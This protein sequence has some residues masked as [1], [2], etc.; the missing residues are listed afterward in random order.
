MPNDVP[1]FTALSSVQIQS[2]NGQIIGDVAQGPFLADS[3]VQVITPAAGS[4]VDGSIACV[5]LHPAAGQTINIFVSPPAPVVGTAASV[6][7]A[8]AQATTAGNLLT[9]AVVGDGTEPTT[10]AVGW[11]KAQSVGTPWAALWVKPNCGNNEAAPTFTASN[12]KAPMIAQL[13]EWSGAATAN[14]VNQ[15]GSGAAAPAINQMTAVNA[16]ADG[17]SGDLFL[18]C[19][20]WLVSASGTPSYKSSINN[21]TVGLQ[22]GTATS[23]GGGNNIAAN[24][25]F[26]IIPA[27]KA[28]LPL[29]TVG[30]DWDVSGSSVPAQGTIPS[31]VFA[32]TPGQKYRLN[33]IVASIRPDTAAQASSLIQVKDGTSV[34]WSIYLAAIATIDA[35]DRADLADLRLPGTTGNSMTVALGS[36]GAAVTG[37]VAAGVYL[38]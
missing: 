16:A 3:I 37:G 35:I 29:G 11:V 12:G 7:P 19:I 30:W 5:S 2:Q 26:G 17:E 23:S 28:V 4:V 8:F 1:D 32:A 38:R 13:N 10:A 14:P 18:T 27:S 31:V 33:R 24:F 15:T 22:A 21:N 20:C 25:P 34:I 6:T 36:I 9:A